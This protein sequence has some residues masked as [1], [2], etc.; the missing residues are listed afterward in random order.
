MFEQYL[1]TLVGGVGGVES[2]SCRRHGH[3]V[4]EPLIHVVLIKAPCGVLTSVSSFPRPNPDPESYRSPFFCE[5]RPFVKVFCVE[6]GP[7]LGFKK[8]MKC[9]W[10]M[11]CTD[12]HNLCLRCL[13]PHHQSASCEDCQVLTSKSRKQREQNLLLQRLLEAPR[14]RSRSRSRSRRRSR[15]HSSKSRFRRHSEK[16][17]SLRSGKSQKHKKKHSSHRESRSP[18]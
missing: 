5:F 11:S 3:R 4:L 17:S 8:C 9:T 7:K 15:H 10:K 13:G 14:C 18:S 16:S 2:A 12:P 1:C 6:M